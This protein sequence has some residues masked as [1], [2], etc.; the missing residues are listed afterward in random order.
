MVSVGTR[1]IGHPT[2][3]QI[4][5]VT[6]SSIVVFISFFLFCSK[7]WDCFKT[8]PANEAIVEE[9]E[10][11]QKPKKKPKQ[12]RPKRLG[13][14][15]RDIL[16]KR[17][18]GSNPIINIHTSEDGDY[19]TAIS[20]EQ[21]EIQPLNDAY[22]QHERSKSLGDRAMRAFK[23]FQT[24]MIQPKREEIMKSS[25]PPEPSLRKVSEHVLQHMKFNEEIKGN[26]GVIYFSLSYDFHQQLFT[27]YIEKATG[28]EAKDISGSSDPFVRVL[29]LPD[30][31][32]EMKT[33]GKP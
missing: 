7:C 11:K 6:I 20:M 10:T 33:D 14:R 16:E 32:R 27:V 22:Y 8:E 3:W 13:Q 18:G 23:A 29:L 5:L 30:K 15:R 17:S 24:T 25:K 26:A 12:K 28:L 2:V 4:C 1:P 21:S 19:Q 31:K 9:E